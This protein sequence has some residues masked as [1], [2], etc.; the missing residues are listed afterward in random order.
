MLGL[1]ERSTKPRSLQLEKNTHRDSVGVLRPD[2]LCFR[3]A[4]VCVT[5][6]SNGNGGGDGGRGRCL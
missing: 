3:L 2:A 5:R 6:S 1:M 4:L